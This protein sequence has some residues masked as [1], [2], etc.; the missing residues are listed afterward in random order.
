MLE[1]TFSKSEIKEAVWS[2]DGGKSVGPDGYTFA[3]LQTFW[4]LV[5]ED[6]FLFVQ[7]FHS[8]AKIVKACMASFL[9]LIPKVDNPQTLAEYKPI[10]LVGSLY[11]ILAK[12]QATR[13][14][15]VNGKLVSPKQSIFISGR[16]I[17]DGMLMVNETIDLAKREGRKCLALKIDFEKAYDCVSWNFLRF[18][19]GN[20]GFSEKWMKWME[21]CIFTNSMSVLINGSVTEDFIIERGLRQGDPLS[22][23]LFVLAMDGLTKLVEKAVDLGVYTGFKVSD[24]IIVDV[25]QFVD[26]AIVIPQNLPDIFTKIIVVW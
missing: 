13:L 21:T 5:K 26:D 22:P 23:F 12:L 17:L 7:N 6:I 16:N 1:E 8:R 4:D 15:K 25:L 10:C 3:F 19:L 14:K 2:C 20:I 24:D 11:K 18:M 9:A